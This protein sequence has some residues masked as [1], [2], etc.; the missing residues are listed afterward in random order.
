MSW[1]LSVKGV[2]FRDNGDPDG[3]GFGEHQVETRV[4]QGLAGFAAR[5]P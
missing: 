5:C 3:L 1:R 2:G 4:A